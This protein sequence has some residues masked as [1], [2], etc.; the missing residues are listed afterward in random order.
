MSAARARAF[1]AANAQRKASEPARSE[2]AQKRKLRP[3]QK[4][5]AAT[6][7]DIAETF[8]PA[9]AK[10]KDFDLDIGCANWQGKKGQAG[11]RT[12]AVS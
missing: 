4:S 6:V 7:L 10:E 12:K 11:T 1:A 3:K 2:H 5:E 8:S 9:N